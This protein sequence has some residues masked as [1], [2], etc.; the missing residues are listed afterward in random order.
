MARPTRR[1]PSAVLQ[2]RPCA[3][4]DNGEPLGTV[5]LCR[6]ML[7]RVGVLSIRGKRHLKPV[8][9]A[10]VVF[11]DEKFFRW[12]YQGPAQNS[13]IWVVN[14]E[15][16]IR[17]LDDV[18]L[19]H[20]MARL[21]TDTSSWWWQEDNAPSRDIQLLAWPP[22]SP[23]LSPLDFHLSQ[24]WET[25]LGERQCAHCPISTQ[26][27]LNRRAPLGS[28]ADAWRACAPKAVISSTACDGPAHVRAFCFFRIY[29]PN[30]LTVEQFFFVGAGTC[31]RL[32]SACLD[33]GTGN[34]L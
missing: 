27:S 10:R 29:G 22:C 6:D 7:Q 14:A 34:R 33:L 15:C 20:C 23:D 30:S 4:I 12:N 32:E 5:E 8:D 2:A 9:L 28:F 11:S 3:T 18:Y 26:K 19:P 17:M 25:A 24:G 16:Y 31:K 1:P 13:P 21:G